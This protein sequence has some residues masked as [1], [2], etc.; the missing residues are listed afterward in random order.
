MSI[1]LIF[2]ELCE[3]LFFRWFIVF[4]QFFDKSVRVSR[5][6]W[7]QA[8]GPIFKIQIDGGETKKVVASRLF[9]REKL[10]VPGGKSQLGRR[11]PRVNRL[12]KGPLVLRLAIKPRNPWLPHRPLGIAAV[13]AMRNEF[14]KIEIV[15]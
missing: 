1:F 5:N 14:N 13:D 12:C 6:F 2:R 4:F 7:T 15:T 8:G 9:A 10:M 3:L 11:F